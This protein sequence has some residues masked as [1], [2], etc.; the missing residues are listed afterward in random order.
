MTIFDYIVIGGYLARMFLLGPIY[1]SF[2]KTAKGYFQAGGTMPWWVVGSS[3]F[4]T[5][6]SVWSFT[7]G[8]AKAYETGSLT[9]TSRI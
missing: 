6:F 7:G 3:A 9:F 5:S 1:K 8:A 4:L 2:S